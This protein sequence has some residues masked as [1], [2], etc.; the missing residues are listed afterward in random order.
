MIF[1]HTCQGSSRSLD[2]SLRSDEL[3]LQARAPEPECDEVAEQMLVDY[4]E[5]PA[6][7][8]SDVDVGRV[9]LEALI[10]CRGSERVSFSAATNEPQI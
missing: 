1:G 9:R 6:E 3:V 4:S 10:C 7:H 5:F 2:A 8:S